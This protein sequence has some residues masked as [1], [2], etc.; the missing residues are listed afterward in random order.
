[1]VCGHC[2]LQGALLVDEMLSLAN[3]RGRLVLIASDVAFPNLIIILNI[4]KVL[5]KEATWLGLFV[6]TKCGGVLIDDRW[7]LTAAHCQPG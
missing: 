2:E 1:M 5:I 7:V 4:L 6:K 3:G